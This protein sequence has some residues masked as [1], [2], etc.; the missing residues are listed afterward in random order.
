MNIERFFL[1]FTD[2]QE[3][4]YA[5]HECAHHKSGLH[6]LAVEACALVFFIQK[7]QKMDNKT[8]ITRMRRPAKRTPLLDTVSPLAASTHHCTRAS[9]L[10]AHVP[11]AML[12]SSLVWTF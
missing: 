7:I 4:S 9:Q 12:C 8:T 5:K 3:S 10:L 1:T 2:S 11:A 6:M